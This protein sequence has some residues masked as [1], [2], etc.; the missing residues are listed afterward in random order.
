MSAIDEIKARANVIDLISR[1]TP[2]KRAGSIYKGNCPFHSERT[3]S[4][5][6][7][8]H[9]GTWHCFGACGTGGDVFSFLM[10]KENLEFRD[11][12]ETLARDLGVTLEDRPAEGDAA[13]K[14]SLFEVNEAAVA[15]FREVLLHHPAA[16]PARGYMERRQIDAA[17]AERFK[18]GFALDNWNALRDHLQ[19][20]GFGYDVQLAAGLI[21]RHEERE[22]IYDAFRN[23]V[24][25][26]IRDRQGRTIGFGGR[27]L[28]DSQPKYLN[29]AETPALHKSHV[30]YGIDF[31]HQ[32]IRAADRV[33]IVE[34]YMDVIAAHQHG[35]ANVV[36]CMGTALTP[37]QL[38]QL[39]RYTNNFV[40]ALDADAAGQAATI[41]GLNQARQA[42]RRVAKPTVLP[43]GRLQLAER[44]D[45]NLAIISMPEGQD[46]DDVVRRDPELWLRLV[47][48]AQPLVDFYFAAVSR[49][50]DLRS[51][52]GRGQLVAELTPLI[53]ELED[54]L[55]RQQYVQQLARLAQVDELIVES[56]VRAAART[57]QLGLQPGENRRRG[58]PSA[59]PGRSR[60]PTA[61]DRL[62]EPPPDGD[63]GGLAQDISFGG[64]VPVPAGSPAS[65]VRAVDY[66]DHVLAMM[67]HSPDL[68]VWLAQAADRLQIH[69]PQAAD[70][71]RADNQEIF[72]A[73][74]R[75][76]SS[77][78]PWDLELFQDALAPPL[79]PKL[80]QLVA[81]G[82]QLPPRTDLELH[83]GMIKDIVHLRLQRLKAE[84]MAVKM[85]VDEAQRSG[86]LDSARS[87]GSAYGRI[88][89][90]LDRLQPLKLRQ[91]HPHDNRPA[92]R[93]D[94]ELHS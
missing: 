31:A 11:A 5:V 20:L 72:R 94:I 23:R 27:V 62:P 26:P 91:N 90:E 25:I 53:A 52:A 88:Q 60:A 38:R 70:L 64:P 33:V 80:G 89:R 63:W 37:E 93:P 13:Q 17:T 15:Y 83:E 68:L 67:L 73:L 18:L 43:G 75:F 81:Y 45:A 69:P 78:E 48:H 4:F 14:S 42:L 16:Q 8:P 84:S 19:R 65:A 82:A 46:P 87:F 92:R 6:V 30:V 76:I 34:G 51:V 59:R 35:F 61:G 44:L 47:E 39:Q 40:L 55:E 32:P 85:L 10:R 7:F 12:L 41:R 36:A 3:P 54:D 77:D 2:L 28:D 66:E 1:Y 56:R 21:K 29:T 22:S 74:K 9:T 79:H 86:E 58:Q 49:K 50:A 24:M 71:D 57:S